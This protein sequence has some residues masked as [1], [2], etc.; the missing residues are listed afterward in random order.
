[1]SQIPTNIGKETVLKLAGK[2]KVGVV[3]VGHDPFADATSP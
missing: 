3:Y 1:V 2:G